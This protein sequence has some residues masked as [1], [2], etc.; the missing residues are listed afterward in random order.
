MEKYPAALNLFEED[1]GTSLS[2]CAKQV[3]EF[4]QKYR[5]QRVPAET[6]RELYAE[7][8]FDHFAGTL[9]RVIGEEI[10]EAKK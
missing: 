4:C 3:R 1:I 10:R 7:N 5:G 8:T 2:D 6:I 9:G